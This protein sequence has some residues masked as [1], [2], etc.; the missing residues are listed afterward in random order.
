MSDY[1]YSFLS[2]IK[3]EAKAYAKA[4]G[5]TVTSAQEHIAKCNGFSGF[6]EMITVSKRNPDDPRLLKAALGVEALDIKVWL[7]PFRHEVVDFLMASLESV[8]EKTNAHLFFDDFEE[9]VFLSGYDPKTGIASF[10]MQTQFHG[11][12]I[13]GQP[14]RGD[15]VGVIFNTYVAWRDGQWKLRDT[16]GVVIR[17]ICVN[18]DPDSED[19]Y[20]PYGYGPDWKERLEKLPACG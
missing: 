4:N 3:R 8:F 5:L 12:H 2:L 16:D 9:E 18:W 11:T 7:H 10:L 6:H 19:N 15:G 20:D 17:A 13:Y 14:F 1:K